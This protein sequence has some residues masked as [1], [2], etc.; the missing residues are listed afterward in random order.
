MDRNETSSEIPGA[1]SKY[2]FAKD[3]FNETTWEMPG[4]NFAFE[5][6]FD[7]DAWITW[8]DTSWLYIGIPI[9]VLYVALVYIGRSLMSTREPFSLRGPLFIWNVSLALFSIIGAYRD[10]PAMINAVYHDGWHASICDNTYYQPKYRVIWGL[11][12]CFSKVPELLDTLFIVLRKQKLIFLHWYHHAAVVTFAFYEFSG[13]AEIARWFSF[14]NFS[15]HSLMYSYYAI[16][17]A[18][19]KLPKPVAI[20]ITSS[21]IIQMIAGSYFVSYALAMK[22]TGQHCDVTTGR[23]T[24]AMI[25]YVSFGI[26]FI[27]FFIQSYLKPRPS[28]VKDKIGKQH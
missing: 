21:Q 16:R 6:N 28:P 4:G 7:V 27:N 24:Y 5:D 26:L 11:I 19:Y 12:F 18:G 10:C 20:S 13:R 22:L 25:M 14:M 3:H 8:A 17:A 9:T 23:L 1:G 15:V 2:A